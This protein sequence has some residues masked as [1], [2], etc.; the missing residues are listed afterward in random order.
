ME[1]LR[2]ETEFKGYDKEEVEQYI[3]AKEG[4]YA[5][6]MRRLEEKN[7]EL[8]KKLAQKEQEY[9]ELEEKIETKYK[10]Y[11]DNYDKIAGLVFESQVK[12][13]EILKEAHEKEAQILADADVAAKAKVDAVQ[14][15]VELCME[16][17]RARYKDIQSQ[18]SEIVE[19]LNA[20]QQRF[21]TGFREVHDILDKMP[22]TLDEHIDSDAAVSYAYGNNDADEFEEEVSSE[23]SGD[24]ENISN[25]EDIEVLD[26]GDETSGEPAKAEDIE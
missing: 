17:G 10:S 9:A 25:P 21:M 22:D 13:D 19:S 7:K 12:A 18:I 6:A 3:R 1:E 14:S 15:D 11:V 4:E 24:L 8:E 26:L 5:V 2:F 20:A 16:D 23:E